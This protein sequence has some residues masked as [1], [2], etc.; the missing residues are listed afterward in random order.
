MPRRV[1]PTSNSGP[2]ASALAPPPGLAL[3]PLLQRLDHEV[4]HR[5]VRLHAVKLELAMEMLG[6]ARCELDPDFRFSCHKYPHSLPRL[7]YLQNYRDS[8]FVATTPDRTEMRDRPEDESLVN[9]TSGHSGMPRKES[10]RTKRSSDATSAHPKVLWCPDGTMVLEA[11]AMWGRGQ[12]RRRDRSPDRARPSFS[13]RALRTKLCIRTS[14]RTQNS[15]RSR[16][17]RRG[18]RVANC[19]RFS[20]S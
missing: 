4:H 11:G 12:A 9:S 18:I 19:T 10:F 3:Q 7:Q 17:M 2:S 20:S 13:A 5:D 1:V 6:D 8:R 14:L 15:F 16:A